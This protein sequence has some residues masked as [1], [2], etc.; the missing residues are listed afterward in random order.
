MIHKEPEQVRDSDTSS[1]QTRE[2]LAFFAPLREIL[3]ILVESYNQR[4]HR[5]RVQNKTTGTSR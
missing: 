5:E 2:N 1:T 4:I 3:G